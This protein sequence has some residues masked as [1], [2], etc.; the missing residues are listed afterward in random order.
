MRELVLTPKFSRSYRKFVRRNRIM[1]RRIDETLGQLRNDVFAAH[2][3]AHKLSG[4]LLGLWACSCGYDCRIVF[5][6]EIDPATGD[7]VVLL[8]DI[9]TH[10]E[11]Y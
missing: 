11:V 3:G 7:E 2:L 8:L 1:Q 5:A 4:E 10:D 6:L 9:G